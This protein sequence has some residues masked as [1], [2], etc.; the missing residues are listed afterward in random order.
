EGPA[1]LQRARDQGAFRRSG[2]A[3]G[4]AGRATPL[5]PEAWL[6]GA[7]EHQTRPGDTRREPRPPDAREKPQVAD[8]ATRPH[9]QRGSDR[10][11]RDALARLF[12]KR[13]LAVSPESAA[14]CVGQA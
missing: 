9:W 11:G 5:R 6:G 8:D 12:E 2:P 1:L 7:S 14:D 10:L 4:G 13:C 3:T